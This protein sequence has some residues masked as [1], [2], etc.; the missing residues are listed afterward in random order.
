VVKRD[1]L[2]I[3]SVIMSLAKMIH[4]LAISLNT[5]ARNRPYLDAALHEFKKS[6][7]THFSNWE[8]GY[9]PN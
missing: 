5:D 3:E 9:I 1:M 6:A 7:A 8:K 4:S 2:T